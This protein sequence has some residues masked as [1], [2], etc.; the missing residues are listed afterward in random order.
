MIELFQELKEK[1]SLKIARHRLWEV[2]SKR[3]MKECNPAASR[4][5]RVIIHSDYRREA[6]LAAR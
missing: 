5:A 4:I 1:H 3:A 6:E 2:A